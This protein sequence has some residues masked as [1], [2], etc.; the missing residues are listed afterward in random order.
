[1][2]H[3]HSNI[4]KTLCTNLAALQQALVE[5]P[6]QAGLLNAYFQIAT[7][8][9]K[10]PQAQCFLDGL[11][12]KHRW[13]H[14]IRRSRIAL[15]LHQKN[16]AAAMTA[17]ETLVAF[18][19]PDDGL[20]DSA[21]AIRAQLGSRS[22]DRNAASKPSIS[23]C[24]I[25]RDER[26]F[27][28]PCLNSIKYLVDEIIVVDTGSKDRSADI[29]RIFGARVYHEKWQDDFALARNDS[30]DKAQG[31]WILILDADE[32]IA[33]KDF[34]ALRQMIA[35]NNKTKSPGNSSALTGIFS[36]IA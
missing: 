36:F 9:G 8:L 25:V 15:S 16:Y 6:D 33:Q 35:S 29:A 19:T 17:V 1:M 32:V 24:M 21:L 3:S 23:L 14:S 26:A 34:E 12:K 20:L 5:N 2:T 11:Q 18:S 7:D 4:D 28:G 22:I 10:L 27:L 13:N 30:I 31:D